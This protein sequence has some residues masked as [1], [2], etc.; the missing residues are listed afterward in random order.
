MEGCLNREIFQKTYSCV[1]LWWLDQLRISRLRGYL[2]SSSPY[3]GTNCWGCC[4][5]QRRNAGQRTEWLEEEGEKNETQQDW[6]KPQAPFGVFSK[7]LNSE[8]WQAPGKVFLLVATNEWLPCRNDHSSLSRSGAQRPPNASRKRG[9]ETLHALLNPLSVTSFQRISEMG[10]NLPCFFPVWF[11]IVLFLRG[12]RLEEGEE[13]V[14]G[15]LE[16]RRNGWLCPAQTGPS[17]K[18]VCC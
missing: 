9:T 16:V 12:G 3:S 11:V 1:W 14:E 10:T 13:M 5:Q 4:G 2:A 8:A 15:S 17:S 7:P 18:G 6:R